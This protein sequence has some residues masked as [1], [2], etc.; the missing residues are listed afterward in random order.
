[1]KQSV[2]DIEIHV[3]DEH[4]L[5]VVRFMDGAE[6]NDEF[7]AWISLDALIKVLSESWKISK[8]KV[9]VFRECPS[10]KTADAR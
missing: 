10:A 1:M 9:R 2:S 7:A 3:S 6:V 5:V 4:Y 8:E